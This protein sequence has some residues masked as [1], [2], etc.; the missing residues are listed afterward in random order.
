M[1]NLILNKDILRFLFVFLEQKFSFDSIE[2]TIIPHRW[3]H[4]VEIKIRR[5]AGAAVCPESLLQAR[6]RCFE[7]LCIRRFVCAGV[8][9]QGMERG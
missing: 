9:R 6:R 2:S 1:I 4:Q 7:G 5:R 3:H 8:S